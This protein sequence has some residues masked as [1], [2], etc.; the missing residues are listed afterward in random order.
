M[1]DLTGV[2]Y[3]QRAVRRGDE[4]KTH[5]SD[6][7]ACMHATSLRRR[8]EQPAPLTQTDL[9]K[10]QAGHDYEHGVAR[11]LREI[12]HRVEEGIDLPV[13]GL[14]SCHPDLLVNDNLVIETKTTDSRTPKEVCQPHHAFQVSAS[15]FAIAENRGVGPLPGVVLVRHASHVETAYSVDPEPWEALI[16]DR[17]EM[18]IEMTDPSRPI[19]APYPLSTVELPDHL[20]KFN[21]PKAKGAS[22]QA[23]MILPYDECGYCRWTQCPANPKRNAFI[24]KAS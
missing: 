20:K 9:V 22:P 16:R 3:G 8:G 19:P 1:I 12:G 6:L 24:N 21:P 5:A 4:L 11:T 15:S 7:W 18:V 10:F 2:L 14:E 13:A 23:G 17:A